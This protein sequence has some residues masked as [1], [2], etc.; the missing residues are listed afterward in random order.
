MTDAKRA[1][2][3]VPIHDLIASR[4]SPRAIDQDRPVGRAQVT[5]L[6]EAARWAPS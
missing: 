4:W 1:T 2:T 3:A 5:A 6:L